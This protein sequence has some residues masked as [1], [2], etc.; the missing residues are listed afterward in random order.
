MKKALSLCFGFFCIFTLSIMTITSSVTPQTYPGN[1]ANSYIPPPG[2]IRYEIPGNG[3]MGTYT[4]KFNNQGIAD[5]NGANEFIVTIG[6]YPGN[7][8]TEVLTWNS[9]FPIFAVIVKG[10]DAY[11][12][13]QY[14]PGVRNDTNLVSPDNASGKPADVSHVAIVISKIIPTQ[15]PTQCP[16]QKPTQCP[17]QKP[18]QKPTQ[19]P[20][21]KPTQCPTQKPTQCPTVKPTDKPCPTTEPHPPTSDNGMLIYIGIILMTIIIGSIILSKL[22]SAIRYR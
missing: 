16:T 10:G 1:D 19:C 4:V 11:N 3:A 21:Q 17:T 7:D 20:T 5:P 15:K 14:Q 9:N 13:Y 8:Y 6:T 2:H 18:T 12:L 22:Y